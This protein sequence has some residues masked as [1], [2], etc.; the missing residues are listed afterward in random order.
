MSPY[1]PFNGEP[2]SPAMGIK[3][4]DLIEWFQPD[5]SLAQDLDEK[6]AILATAPHLAL[7]VVAEPALAAETS[8]ATVELLRLVIENLTRYHPLH[9]AL[10]PRGIR[11]RASSH[12]VQVPDANS[13]C[14]AGTL[15][16]R[17]AGIVQ[18][19][20]CLLSP[21]R[22]ARLAAG[23]VC[24]PS[25]WNIADKVGLDASAIHE[26]VPGFAQTL[27]Q[28]TTSFLDRLTPERSFARL[29]W[30]IHDSALRF[31]PHSV[32]GRADLTP[33]N[34]LG[35][36]FLRIERQTLRRLPSSGF[37]VFTIR[38]YIDRLD[39]LVNDPD[40][41]KRLLG[42]LSS[43]PEEAVAYKGMTRFFRPLLQALA[44]RAG[45]Q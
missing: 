43:M 36:T 24:F 21:N 32:A 6:R 4:L 28:P 18:E 27:A 42:T 37:V 12:T 14:D 30:T 17:I 41:R 31:A 5:A 26:P 25:R 15:L 34:V 2:Y 23:L 40:R 3:P 33:E 19:D 9:Y 13:E 1:F 39:G 22:P 38:T 29:N 45:S 44:N 8:K 11:I 7:A 10:D 16:R 20:V 35:E